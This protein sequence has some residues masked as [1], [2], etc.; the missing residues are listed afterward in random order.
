MKKNII[1]GIWLFLTVFCYAQTNLS[2]GESLMMQNKPSEAVV[3]LENAVSDDSSNTKAYLYLGIVYE[4]LNRPNEAVAVYR[5]ALPIAG[6]SSA[7]VASNLGN[8]YFQIG[9]NEMAEQYY[10]QA[11]G[12][13]SGYSKA[14]L[15]R[16]NTRIKA[17]NLQNAVSDYEQ[18]LTL[19]PNSNQ[20]AKIEQLMALIK[21]EFAAEERRKVFAEEEERR[22]AEERKKLLDSVSA[23]LHSAADAS[24]SLSSGAE[25]VEQYDGEFVLD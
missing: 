17:G 25:N 8:V 5:R 21:S 13:N 20:K 6:S 16:A 11:I 19:E 3:Y 14:Y 18:Y 12:F 9:N 1:A 23:S 24:K 2:R 7:N 4:Q 22:V 15:G 10:S